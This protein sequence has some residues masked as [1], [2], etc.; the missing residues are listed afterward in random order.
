M[1]KIIS[2]GDSNNTKEAKMRAMLDN[3]LDKQA[4]LL[5]SARRINILLMNKLR[6]VPFNARC[7]PRCIIYYMIPGG[8]RAVLARG[9]LI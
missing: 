5:V 4:K 7:Q 2:S 6:M 1:N 3:L 8:M 9:A